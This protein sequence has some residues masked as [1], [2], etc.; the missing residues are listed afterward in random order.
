MKIAVGMLAFSLMVFASDGFAGTQ[1]VCGTKETSLGDSYSYCIQTGNRAKTQDVVYF[2]HGLWGNARQFFEQRRDTAWVLKRWAQLGYEPSIVTVS[3]GEIWL[4]VNNDKFPLIPL[5]QNEMMPF[6]EGQLGGLGNGRR[7]LMGESMG[8]FNASQAAL[9]LPA[10]FA[11]V[12]LLCPALT[13]IGPYSSQAEIDQYI[14]RTKALRSRVDL[15]LGISRE[16]FADDTDWQ[17]HNPFNLLQRYSS[18]IKPVFFVST[19]L[20]DEFGFQEGS[21]EFAKAAQGQG[22]SATW[23]PLAGRHCKYNR[24]ALAQFFLSRVR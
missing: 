8:G 24:E 14:S 7:L 11:K 6:L 15:M 12:A 4:L 22:F 3:F 21:A 18:M 20:Q 1:P 19:G 10:T 23:V 9:Q 16:V 17:N 5:F 2:F 13:V